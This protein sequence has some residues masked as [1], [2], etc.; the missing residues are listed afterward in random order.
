MRGS[1]F[2]IRDL[3]AYWG[4]DSGL[5]VRTAFFGMPNM[6]IGITGLDENLGQDDWIK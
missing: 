3:K 5:K 6:T 2:G 4:Q 1:G